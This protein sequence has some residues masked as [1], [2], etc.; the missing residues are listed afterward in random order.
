MI[1]LCSIG[2]RIHSSGLL[3]AIQSSRYQPFVVGSYVWLELSFG[4]CEGQAVWVAVE[5]VFDVGNVLHVGIAVFIDDVDDALDHLLLG[6]LVADC[7][8]VGEVFAQP[9]LHDSSFVDSDV[10][11]LHFKKIADF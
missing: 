5:V 8:A 9:D 11:L 3:N 1:N 7:G 2:D 10:G 6:D 4:V